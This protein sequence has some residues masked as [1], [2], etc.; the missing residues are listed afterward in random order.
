MKFL[1]HHPDHTWGAVRVFAVLTLAA[2]LFHLFGPRIAARRPFSSGS[3]SVAPSD[4]TGRFYGERLPVELEFFQG[5]GAG[6]AR[7]PFPARGQI[8]TADESYRQEFYGTY[9]GGADAWTGTLRSAPFRVQTPYLYLPITGYPASPGNRLALCVLK[10]D[11]KV[12]ERLV[13]AGLKAR[14]AI[15]MWE[16][17]CRRFRGAEAF[18]ELTD[19][20]KESGGWL[21]V[22]R[23]VFS[24]RS[25]LGS[26]AVEAPT[27]DYGGL[28][29]SAFLLVGVLF[30]PGVALAARRPESIFAEPAYVALPGL[31]L[32][33]GYGLGLWIFGLAK[34]FFLG[35]LVTGALALVAGWLARR[36]GRLR[37]GVGGWWPLRFYGIFLLL[38]LQYSCLPL[39]VWR[40][41]YDSTNMRSRMVAGPPDHGIPFSA[42]CYFFHG[43]DGRVRSDTYFGVDWSLTSRGP[44]ISFATTAALNVFGITPHD[45]PE[46]G[47][48]FSWPADQEGFFLSRILGVATNAL[49]LL[50]AGTLALRLGARGRAGLALCLGWLALSPVLTVNTVFVWPKLLA[51]YFL[52]VAAGEIFAGG[53]TRRIAPCLALSYLSHPVGIFFLPVLILLRARLRAGGPPVWRAE[54]VRRWATAGAWLGA[55]TLLCLLPWLI[56]KWRLGHPDHFLQYP[57]SDGRGIQPAISLGTW[58]QSRWN[59]LFYTLMPTGFWFSERFTEWFGLHPSPV[60]RWNIQYT[61]TLAPSLGFSCFV[62]A[63]WRWVEPERRLGLRLMRLYTLT[64]PLAFMLLLWGYSDDGLG[65]DC[66]QP[67]VVFLIIY[68]AAQ[69][70]PAKLLFKIALVG[71][72]AETLWVLL[73]GLFTYPRFAFSQLELG[74]WVQLAVLAATEAGLLAMTLRLSRRRPEAAPAAVLP[75]HRGLPVSAGA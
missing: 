9:V 43:Y 44:L 18:L 54:W 42:A 14:E 2:L 71:L 59:G 11:G 57:L 29:F 55:G 17:D 8:F 7:V 45:P 61:K 5:T 51:T 70:D 20:L 13:C 38:C 41:G 26:Q 68:T 34:V 47:P 69:L 40:E 49:V 22:S 65:R 56:F 50:A 4:A 60:V 67:I 72:M 31:L 53:P 12:G 28:Y 21:G 33:A 16:V 15:V 3:A 39:N 64:I 23:P 62:V 58:L 35:K 24:E 30:L 75:A 25:G 1:H 66:L 37:L 52:V 46:N 19:G 10:S 36:G 73:S 27:R 6:G 74:H 63:Y 32:L 48:Q